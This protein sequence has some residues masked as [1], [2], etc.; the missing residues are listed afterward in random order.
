MGLAI[1]VELQ[2]PGFYPAGG[3]D[4]TSVAP[5]QH[6]LTNIEVIKQFLPTQFALNQM[7]E[8]SY[9]IAIVSGEY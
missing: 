3:G 7:A 2:R 8:D 1:K 9:L 6:T 4:F 5:S